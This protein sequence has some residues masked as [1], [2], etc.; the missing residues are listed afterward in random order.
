MPKLICDKPAQSEQVTYYTLAGLPGDPRVDHDPV[1]GNGLNYELNWL[2]PGLYSLRASAC[3]A[4]QCS[5]PSPLDFTVP[6]AP[7]QP[8]GLSISFTS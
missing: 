2:P 6:E 4:W 8:A 5:L 7:S 1:L 3:N